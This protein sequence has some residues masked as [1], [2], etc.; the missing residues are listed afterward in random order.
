MR[1]LLVAVGCGSLAVLGPLLVPATARPMPSPPR[2][3]TISPPGPFF[4]EATL[5]RTPAA[6]LF[7]VRLVAAFM[8]IPANGRPEGRRIWGCVS[9][10]VAGWSCSAVPTGGAEDLADP[11]LAWSTADCPSWQGVVLAGLASW[12]D[13]APRPVLWRLGATGWIGPVMPPDLSA[14][15]AD[16]PKIVASGSRLYLAYRSYT[17]ADQDVAVSQGCTW[18]SP[19]PE[20]GGQDHPRLTDVPGGSAS[21]VG[22]TPGQLLVFTALDG[23]RPTMVSVAGVSGTAF[24]DGPDGLESDVGRTLLYAGGAYDL[25]YRD[26][27]GYLQLTSSADGGRSWSAP[28]LVAGRDSF[29]PDLAWDGSCLVVSYE[30]RMGGS[31]GLQLRT[32]AA[33]GAPLS[34]AVTLASTSDRTPSHDELR[35]GDY[36][37][38]VASAGEADVAYQDVVGSTS[39]IELV[40]AAYACS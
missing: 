4:R 3:E 28:L 29:E 39:R 8:E 18:S 33:P 22:T 34:D 19:V 21:L 25:L 17:T 24:P 15:P 27:V 30:Q 32:Q 14:D 9:L 31:A 1:R 36:I 26:P 2:Y 23:S 37:G 38:M 16:G 40:R 7:G 5:I 11:W 10:P 12:R 13:Q 20:V 6:S 35:F